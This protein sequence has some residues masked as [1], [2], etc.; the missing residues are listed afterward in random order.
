ML[1]EEGSFVQP[2]GIISP[3]DSWHNVGD[4]GEPAF[5]NSWTNYAGYQ[6]A[7][8]LKDAAGVV[9]IEGV[10]DSGS[11]TIFTL[12]AGYRPSAKLLIDARGNSG[13]GYLEID[14]DGTVDYVAGGTTWFT[15]HC[16]FYTG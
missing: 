7:R 2:R 13:V 4:A 11:G 9:H 15:I 5:V 10:V 3:D 16:S 6:V 1:R 8:F 12:P 14:T